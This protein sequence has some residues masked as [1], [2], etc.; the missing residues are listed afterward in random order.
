MK[1]LIIA[2]IACIICLILFLAKKRHP[3]NYV[4]VIA[5]AGIAM[6]GAHFIKFSSTDDY[7][8]GK[9]TVDNP[10]GTVTFSISCD[11]VAGREEHIPDNGVILAKTEFE[12]EEGD[13]AYTILTR[14]AK[15]FRI[16]FE[17]NG[18]PTSVYI[19]GI[20]NIYEGDFGDMSGW[21]MK[22]NGEFPSVGAGE[23]I[24]KDGDFIEWM[25]TD[26]F[27]EEFE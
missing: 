14:A 3:L 11:K 27:M 23:C 2:G 10:V 16:Q 20:A 18:T 19:T 4:A 24:L 22:M 7:Y 9:V 12:F 13:T 26:N 8:S 17:N 15:E 5:V 6:I 25:Y 1:Y 21:L